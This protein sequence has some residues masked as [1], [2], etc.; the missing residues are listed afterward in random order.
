MSDRQT[1]AV[2]VLPTDRWAEVQHSLKGC[3]AYA[4]T[5][6][7]D[8]LAELVGEDESL[9]EAI[10]ANGFTAAPVPTDETPTEEAA[11]LTKRA[12]RRKA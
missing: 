1:I 12:N 7:G 2:I 11:R 3:V 9:V 6:E 5:P 4:E 8:R 10:R